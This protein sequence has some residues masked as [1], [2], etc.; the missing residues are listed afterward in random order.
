MKRRVDSIFVKCFFNK[1]KFFV[2][3]TS[4]ICLVAIRQKNCLEKETK[5]QVSFVDFT[6]FLKLFL[7]LLH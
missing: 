1:M 2:E 6:K 4:G 7:Y 3:L 5:S